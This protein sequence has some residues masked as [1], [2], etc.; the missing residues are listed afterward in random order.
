MKNF[1]GYRQER[2][3]PIRNRHQAVAREHRRVEVELRD[4]GRCRT[5]IPQDQDYGQH[6]G[7]DSTKHY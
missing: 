1:S 7:Q 5:G 2:P 4:H 6:P 3:T